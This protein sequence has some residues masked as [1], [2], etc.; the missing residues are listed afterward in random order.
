MSEVTRLPRI[1]SID[2]VPPWQCPSKSRKCTGPI[3][4][5]PVVWLLWT[6]DDTYPVIKRTAKTA[7]AAKAQAEVV[8]HCHRSAIHCK[9]LP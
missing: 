1:L 7:D 2:D 8:F 6:S 5:G 3:P 9:Q 4:I